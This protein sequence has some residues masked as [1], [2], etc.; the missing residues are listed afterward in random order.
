MTNLKDKLTIDKALLLTTGLA[1]SAGLVVTQNSVLLLRLYH[2]VTGKN[3]ISPHLRQA[4][5][6]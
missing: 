2:G 6:R 3:F 4:A 1:A 5:E